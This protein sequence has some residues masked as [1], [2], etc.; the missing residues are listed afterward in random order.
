[1]PTNVTEIK[2]FISCPSDV[3]T[4]KALIKVVCEEINQRFRNRYDV[5]LFALDWRQS[6]VP[7]FGPRTQGIINEQIGEYD[8]FIGI[9]WKRFGTPTGA[10]NS[11]TGLDYESGTEEEFQLAYD[12][13]KE[14]QVPLINF[15]F[16]TEMHRMPDASEMEQL[17][18]V[19]TF[20]QRLKE[21][22]HGWVVDFD[23]ELD[24]ERKVRNF[25]ENVFLDVSDSL[26]K[27]KPESSEPTDLIDLTNV[28]KQDYKAP[29]NYLPRRVALA[30]E[31]GSVKYS[32]L[33]Y[34]NSQD[35]LTVVVQKNRVV[36]LS[37]AGAGKST[38]LKRIA[39]HFSKSDHPL[40]PYFLRLNRY[41]NQAISDLLPSHWK[42][43]PDKNLLVLLDGLDEIESQNRNNAIRQIELFAEQHPASHIVVSCRSNFYRTGTKLSSGSLKDFD[44][45]I[46]LNLN[47][48]E[49]YE[50]LK[51]QLGERANSFERLISEK[52]LWPLVEIPFY[53]LHLVSLFKTQEGLPSNKAQIFEQLLSEQIEFD[54]DKF[55]TTINLAE[56]PFEIISTLEIVALAMESL[57]RNNIST[58]EYHKIIPDESK[59][60]LLKHCAVWKGP[61]GNSQHWRFEH[62]NFQ[63]YLAARILSRQLIEII[64]DFIA[65]PPDHRKIIPSWINTLSFLVS[66]IKKEAPLYEQIISW[67]ID[68]EPEVVV[69]FEPDKIDSTTRVDLVK[70]IFNYYK[71]RQIPIDR[72][73]FDYSELARFG[74]S[75]E[76]IDFLL[77]EAENA[78]HF[79]ILV[80]AIELLGDSEIPF[81]QRQRATKLLVNTALDFEAGEYP[82]YNALRALT[83]LRL[84]SQEIINQL[85]PALR[86][87]ES[88]WV[89]SGLYYLLYNSDYLDENID[90]FLEGIKYTEIVIA[91]AT[92]MG[93]TTR[94]R[95][96][97]E[98]WH[99][100]KGLERA[101]SA[102]AIKKILAY[103]TE[104]PNDLDRYSFGEVIA[105]IAENAAK[106]Y[107]D[108]PSIFEAAAVFFAAEHKSNDERRAGAFIHFFDLTNTRLQAFQKFFAER[109][110]NRDAFSLL[111]FVADSQCIQYFA[112]QYEER[113]VTND[114]VWTFQYQLNWLNPDLS[115]S[116]NKMMNEI[117]GDKFIPQPAPDMKK[118]RKEH[119]IDD[120]NLLFDKEAFL[121]E[122]NLVFEKTQKETLTKDD[123][124]E[125]RKE[126]W[127]S[128]TLSNLAIQTIGDFVRNNPASLEHIVETINKSDWDFY[129]ATK[130]Y[131]K[132]SNNK[133]LALTEEQEKILAQW[134]YANLDKVDFKTALVQ[135][136]EGGGTTSWLAILLWYYLRRLHLKYPKE[137]LLDMLSFEWIEGHQWVGIEYL[138]E[139]LDESDITQRILENLERGI[140]PDDVLRNHY[141][142]A[143]QHS[144][145]EVIP[146][147]L[148]DITNPGRSGWVRETALET[149]YELSESPLILEQALS[150]IT[151]EFKW[152]VVDKLI[153]KDGGLT[154]QFLLN[155]LKNGDEE[156]R[157]T[158]AQYLIRLQEIEGLSYYADWIERNMQFT[159]YHSETFSLRELK[160]PAA[161]PL[162]MKLLD[163]S[164]REGLVQSDFH[165][166]NRAVLDT[167]NRVAL[168]SEDSYKAVRSS[169]KKFIEENI[170]TYKGV[171]FLYQY[172]DSL[173]RS[174]YINKSNQITLPEV[175]VKIREITKS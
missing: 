103:F 47:H 20:K 129:R 163:L 79:T 175:I 95:L 101:I 48:R 169:I 142:Y 63:E 125:I 16:K 126:Q 44:S 102:T 144:V 4:E 135:K 57:G 64:K 68:S 26:G 75:E 61:D 27:K 166:L 149:V 65:F 7:L 141:K 110:V 104:N 55:R 136:P 105:T 5:S 85:L 109:N 10:Q 71:E 160:T 80:N 69:K 93:T 84:N 132:L 124:Y 147:A 34:R 156:E 99:L 17:S 40:F 167:L 88:D 162:L 12:S 23:S 148:A 89:R 140:G 91:D 92:P 90:V 43:I 137:V 49:V 154:H 106:A 151:D 70:Q 39:A 130:V 36:L 146:F 50:Y 24:F 18:K 58:E 60:T 28:A 157:L 97:D 9:L 150:K 15:Y 42:E 123:L 56:K 98:Y 158:A 152:K 134:C 108:D 116:F 67:I 19:T 173:E 118:E 133:E 53:L 8:V 119:R 159:E 25:L 161:I 32:F 128:P 171:N 21:E 46:L 45:Y 117:S 111:A 112:W 3:E 74:Q 72:D 66:A 76:M 165:T 82:Q 59:R 86:T 87:S 127:Q 107:A 22:C 62:N 51:D 35:T 14:K 13:W 30:E 83:D 6:V 52:H 131:E 78:S 54:V 29:L 120:L 174:F 73:K 1:M 153:G 37:D 114:D 143:K 115:L 138:E 38:E 77:N 164:Y 96:F 113:N 121:N 145:R 172:I 94:S 122:I 168:Q 11:Q 100:S 139:L 31:D 155:I 33:A 81:N 170:S 41:T 2:V